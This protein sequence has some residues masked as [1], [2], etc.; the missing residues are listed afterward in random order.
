M[1]VDINKKVLKQLAIDYDIFFYKIERNGAEFKEYEEANKNAKEKRNIFSRS[2]FLSVLCLENKIVFNGNSEIILWCKKNYT[3]YPVEWFMNYQ[4]LN[5]LNN[6]IN[7]YGYRISRYSHHYYIPSSIK[8]SVSMKYKMAWISPD[9]LGNIQKE[10]IFPNAL[11]GNIYRADQYCIVCYDGDEIIS[12]VSATKNGKYMWELAV[13][14]KEK[15]RNQGIATQLVIRMTNY[16]I[17]R[18]FVTFYGTSE[19]NIASQNV[20]LNAG[21][22]PFWAE[23]YTEKNHF[24]K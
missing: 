19:S 15:Y 17:N 8:K 11:F 18:G 20:A 3:E 13:D 2:N 4:N 7:R 12:I 16:M 9:I 10:K 1:I 24:F 5:L 21:Y 6:E 14:T 23:V 22:R